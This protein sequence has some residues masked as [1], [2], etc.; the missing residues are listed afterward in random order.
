MA[1]RARFTLATA[2]VAQSRRAL[3]AGRPGP[4]AAR[5]DNT[6]TRSP[7][8]RMSAATRSGQQT[9]YPERFHQCEVESLRLFLF[10]GH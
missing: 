1:Q 6:D 3:C 8:N 9:H 7:A 5:S 10:F 4:K 2:V